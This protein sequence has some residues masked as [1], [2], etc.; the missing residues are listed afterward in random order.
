MQAAKDRPL[1]N[2]RLYSSRLYLCCASEGRSEQRVVGAQGVGVNPCP[3]K[4][5]AAMEDEVLRTGC[6]QYVSCLRGFP[7]GF[8]FKTQ[9]YDQ[10]LTQQ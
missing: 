10:G 2:L 7:R 8:P 9:F 5:Q 3:H 1:A 4:V 6:L